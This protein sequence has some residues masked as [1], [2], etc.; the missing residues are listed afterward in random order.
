MY[1]TLV[2]CT[3]YQNN[4]VYFPSGIILSTRQIAV[5][6]VAYVIKQT[7]SF[8]IHIG[9]IWFWWI[10]FQRQPNLGSEERPVTIN[11]VQQSTLF[12]S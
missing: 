3:F 4:R 11:Y 9:F 5:I 8:N 1:K 6:G 7:I 12:F 10:F 2:S